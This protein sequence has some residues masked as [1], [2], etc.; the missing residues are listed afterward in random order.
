MF[1]K[2]LM[3]LLLMFL[4]IFA[5]LSCGTDY[6]L[7]SFYRRNDF[8]WPLSPSQQTNLDYYTHIVGGNNL[9]EYNSPAILATPDNYILSLYENRAQYTDAIFSIDGQQVVNVKIAISKNAETFSVG[10]NVGDMAYTSTAS[11]GSPIGFVDK[12]GNVVVLAVG[13][14]GFG[15][16]GDAKAISDI[17][18]SISTNNGTSWTDWTNIINT[19]IFKPLLDQG[20]NRFYTTSGKG[21]TLR[22]GTLVCMIDYKKYSVS[23]Y[24]PKGAAIIYSKNN[25][26]DWELGATMEYTGAA[27]GKRFAKVILERDDGKLLIAAVGNTENDYNDNR[28]IYW[29]LLDSLN[30][31]ISDFTVSGLL[32]NSGGNIAGDKITFSKDGI[33]KNG[34]ILVHSTP[35]RIYKSPNNI[36]YKVKNAMSISISEDEGKTWTLIK[37]DFGTPPNKTSFRHDLKVLKDGSIVVVGEEGVNLEITSQQPFNVVYRRMGLY[38]L[39][40]GDYSYEG[41]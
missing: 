9:N 35:N 38:A 17:S 24:T 23:G 16:T 31:K 18:V 28:G 26:L 41:P 5:V 1:K 33:L 10:K 34:F 3:F 36:E 20:Y 29:G 22:N 4:L 2:Y 7:S 40:G 14:I 27:L 6:V 8:A 30:G 13:G 39:S 21:I 32:N 19:N 12:N 25:G 15:G 37:D 11:R